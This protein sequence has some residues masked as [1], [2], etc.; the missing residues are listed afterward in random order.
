L[1]REEEKDDFYPVIKQ[2]FGLLKSPE[3]GWEDIM[4]M[5]VSEHHYQQKIL[6]YQEGN[7]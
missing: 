3:K 2:S 7:I 6:G 5:G 4:A 1:A